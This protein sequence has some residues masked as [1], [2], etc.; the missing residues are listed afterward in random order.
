M[1]PFILSCNFETTGSVETEK[2]SEKMTT[3][4][5]I[6]HAE[7]ETADPGEKDPELTEAGK[8][9]AENWAEVFKA[10][11]FDHIYSTDYK[12]TRNTAKAIADSQQK[13]IQLFHKDKFSE[14]LAG[15]EK[16]NKKVLVVG[17]SNTNPDFVNQL[18]AEEKY[19]EFDES[20]YGSLFIVTLGPE[21]SRAVQLLYINKF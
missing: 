11:D 5:F 16:Q 2:T 21:D 18:I 4:Y 7:K 15:E 9:R 17:H 14:E 3:Y 12:R 10:V 1:L 6:R 20:E 19:P 13:D 8:L